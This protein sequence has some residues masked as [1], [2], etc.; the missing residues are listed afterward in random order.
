MQDD[1]RTENA[2]YTSGTSGGLTDSDFIER[3]SFP[4]SALPKK[5]QEMI[6]T[7][8]T[9]LQVSKELVA[10]GMITVVSGAIGN[11]VRVSPKEGWETPPFLWAAVIKESGYGQ[12]PAQNAISTAR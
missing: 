2:S 4:F 11:T 5:I 10:F 3:V 8:S 12:S 6:E 9:G 7:Y 1:R